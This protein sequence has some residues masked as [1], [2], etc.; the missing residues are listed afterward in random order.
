MK[1]FTW[2]HFYYSI[3]EKFT[4]SDFFSLLTLMGPWG[5]CLKGVALFAIWTNLSVLL[6]FNNFFWSHFVFCFSMRFKFYLSLLG[7]VALLLSFF[8]KFQSFVRSHFCISSSLGQANY[9]LSGFFVSLF[10][11]FYLLL[12]LGFARH[13]LLQQFCLGL[14]LPR[15]HAVSH[16]E[17]R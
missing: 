7:F 9:I 17:P 16:S 5:F 8:L 10:S 14:L 13:R 11:K 3:H 1:K 6:W 2:I 4:C 12:Y 15:N